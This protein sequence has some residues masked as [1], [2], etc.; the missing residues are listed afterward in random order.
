[1]TLDKHR[2]D[3]DLKIQRTGG[4]SMRFLVGLLLMCCLTIALSACATQTSKSGEPGATTAGAVPPPSSPLSKI[5]D[6]MRMKEVTD[7]L[8][9]PSDQNSYMTGKAF[10]PWYFGDDARRTSYYYKGI[11]RVVFAGGNVFGGGGGE[12]IRVD[13]DPTENGIAR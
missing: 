6:G 8:G 5:K 4:L 2:R 9:A 3:R 7:I 11:G 10:I 1:V 13:Y 12:V